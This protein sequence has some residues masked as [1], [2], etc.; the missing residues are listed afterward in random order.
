V[1]L[2]LPFDDFSGG[3]LLRKR[4]LRRENQKKSDENDSR[5]PFFHIAPPIL[6][7]GQGRFHSGRT[8]DRKKTVFWGG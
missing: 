5:Q 4:A 2:E 7:A 6:A 1:G 3:R 8:R